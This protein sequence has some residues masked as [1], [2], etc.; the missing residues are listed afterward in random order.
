MNTADQRHGPPSTRVL[1]VE[2]NPGDARLV[3]LQLAEDADPP[4]DVT[5]ARSLAQARVLGAV[6]AF[7][8]VLTDLGLP[9]CTGTETVDAVLAEWPDTPVVVLTGLS[10][11]QTGTL[12]VERGCQDYLIKGFAD[13]ELLHR[14]IRYAIGRSAAAK[15]LRESEERF[16][17]LVDVSPDAIL[18]CDAQKVLFANSRALI[19]FGVRERRELVGIDP[20]RLYPR[21]DWCRLV[22]A[23]IDPTLLN[24]IVEPNRIECRLSRLDGSV[25]DAEV[26][27]AAI[28]HREKP[29]VEVIVRDITERKVAEQHRHLAAV[30]FET[31]DEAMMV[32]DDANNIVAVNPAFERV[33]GYGAAEVIGKN[34]RH[35]ASGRHDLAFYQGMWIALQRT[36]HWHGE[37]W[38]R[39]KNGEIYVQRL[40]LSLIRDADGKVVNHIGVFSDVTDEK[41]EAELIRYRANYDA[42]TGLPNRSLL[43]DRMLQALA[44]TARE[45]GKLGVL[46][47][48]LDGFKSVNDSYG[49]LAGDHLLVA[50]SDRLQACVRESDTVARLGGDEFVIVL[51]D[52]DG[53]AD[54]VTVASKI[55][56]CLTEPFAL[57]DDGDVFVRI[58]AS[59]G[60]ALFP[61]HG[62]NA[63]ELLHAADKAMYSSKELGKGRFEIAEVSGG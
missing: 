33:T 1:V 44:K 60:I 28:V 48:D 39:R 61:L 43:H 21:S 58:G 6:S 16:R 51:P 14:T 52:M 41:Q 40:T 9:D 22:A 53:A 19:T 34:P 37:V 4:F 10:D 42:L 27:M 46:F 30:V 54:A 12:A 26:T 31:T 38:N 36:G 8:V 11:R 20:A 45:G 3:A 63:E 24:G 47:L 56:L 23:L 18:L 13:P 2:D 59:I 15:A 49:H 17:T 32:T 62:R 5:V 25:F 57:N 55:L 29:A 7:D 35:L 50:L